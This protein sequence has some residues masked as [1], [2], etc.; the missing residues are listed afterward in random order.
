M[1]YDNLLAKPIAC[2]KLEQRQLKHLITGGGSR[3][4]AKFP[5]ESYHS[6][7]RYENKKNES[8]TDLIITLSSSSLDDAYPL[9]PPLADLLSFQCQATISATKRFSCIPEAD[10]EG[11]T[12]NLIQLNFKEKN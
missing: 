4:Y 1:N 5:E 3:G 6:L 2:Y 7:R 9:D 12:I 8:L 11:I 10:L